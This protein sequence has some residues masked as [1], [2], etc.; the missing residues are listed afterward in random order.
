MF[1]VNE[2]CIENPKIPDI[3]YS[4]ALIRPGDQKIFDESAPGITPIQN[5]IDKEKL[6]INEEILLKDA[7]SF[8]SPVTENFSA[9]KSQLS[10]ELLAP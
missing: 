3:H 6:A 10:P 4:G 5:S 7:F 1:L 9:D 2:L 8:K